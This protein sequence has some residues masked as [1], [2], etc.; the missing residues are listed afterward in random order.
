MATMMCNEGRYYQNYK[1]REKVLE[2]KKLML[3]QIQ[4]YTAHSLLQ[5]LTFFQKASSE[6]ALCVDKEHPIPI[7]PLTSQLNF[8]KL[9]TPLNSHQQ[10]FQQS[11]Y[12]LYQESLEV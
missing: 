10:L 11:G 1:L 7:A 2:F 12:P 4:I 8:Y 3:F 5:L 6:M 9:P